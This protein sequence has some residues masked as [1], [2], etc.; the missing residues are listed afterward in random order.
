M[1]LAGV[2]TIEEAN[3]F[4]ATYPD[5]HNA[6]F[7][8]EPEREEAAFLPA[9]SPDDLP[10]ILCKRAFR[11]ASGDSTISWKGKK[12]MLLDEKHRQKL[13]KRGA[14]IEVLTLLD[15]SHV[16]LHDGKV[17]RLDVPEDTGD[18]KASLKD[19]AKKTQKNRKEKTPVIPAPDHPWRRWCGDKPNPRKV[20]HSATSAAEEG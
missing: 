10:Y 3:A 14:A 1:R 15:G 9:P 12:L 16:A 7:A 19:T 6:R 4:L 17:H 5:I 13:L 11:K 8:V 2:S 18:R 20:L